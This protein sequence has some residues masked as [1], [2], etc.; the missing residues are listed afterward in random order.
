[1]GGRRPAEWRVPTERQQRA[2]ETARRMREAATAQRSDHD[3]WWASVLADPRA[4]TAR[5]SPSLKLCEIQ[6]GQLRI[7]CSRCSKVIEIQRQ[8]AVDQFGAG[9]TWREV[10]GRLLDDACEIRTGR[11]E[12]D[13]CWPDFGRW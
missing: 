11:H 9:A 7:S 6:S 13:G 10:G 8:D 3:A 4:V 5:P 2:A 12:E 1:M